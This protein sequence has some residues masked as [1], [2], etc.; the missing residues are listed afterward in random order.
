MVK[1]SY[2]IIV[3]G[4]IFL[5]V[6]VFGMLVFKRDRVVAVLLFTA[7]ILGFALTAFPDTVYRWLEG[8]PLPGF[9]KPLY[10][11]VVGLI[12]FIPQVL[13]LVAALIR[14][15]PAQSSR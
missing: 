1:S 5:T 3:G 11:K 10:L 2:E 14:R 13:L 4:A 7:A 9:V 6:L 15:S 8:L 12:G